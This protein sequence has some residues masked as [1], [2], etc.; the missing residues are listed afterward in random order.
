MTAQKPTGVRW[1]IFLALLVMCTITNVDRA[2]ISI[3][4]PAIQ[5]DLKLDPAIVG[6]IFSAFFWGYVSMQIPMGWLADRLRADKLVVA[7]TGFWGVLEIITGMISARSL[8]ML[9]RVLVG[10][11]EAPMYPVSTKMQSIWLTSKERGRG[12]SIFDSGAA[13]GN[14]IGGPLVLLF[15]AWFGGWRGALIGTGLVTIAVA[16]GASFILRGTPDT[17]PRV[18][19]AERQYI[20]QALV[21]EYENQ[22]TV[23]GEPVGAKLYLSNRN[24]WLMCAGYYCVGGFWFGI[25]TWG[26]SYLSSAQHLDIKQIGGAVF[27]IYGIGVLVE[28][29][30][31]YLSDFWRKKGA[32]INTV[33]RTLLFIQGLGMA[34]GMYYVSRSTSATSALIGLIVGASFERVAGCLYWSVPSAIAQRKDV[35]I[36]AGCMNTVGNLAGVITPILIGVI[37]SKTSSYHLALMMFVGFGIA[38]S[39]FSLLLDYG[40]KIGSISRE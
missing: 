24:F 26:P 38:I 19:E 5:R 31:G 17:N 3:C 10:I 29:T 21:E 7:A 8:F 28:I 13:M 34:S 12:V 36:V 27:I 37:V 20:K 9:L 6:V 22:K 40:K 14:A 11:A 18:N 30:G 23:G 39:V 16:W 32:N 15:L 1:S 25:M 35:G 33:M 4:M 2:V